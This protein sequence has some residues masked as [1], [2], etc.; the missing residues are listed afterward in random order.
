MNHSKIYKYKIEEVSK[1][2]TKTKNRDIK[3]LIFYLIYISIFFASFELPKIAFNE[4]ISLG[5]E[6]WLLLGGTL[7]VVF[8]FMS[9][10]Y[11]LELVGLSAWEVN[12]ANN[13]YLVDENNDIY[14]VSAKLNGSNY[15]SRAV[16]TDSSV[17]KVAAL[18]K[19]ISTLRPSGEF[20]M[21]KIV[22][23]YK[24]KKEKDG[25]E[26]ICD[27][28][29]AEIDNWKLKQKIYLSNYYDDYLELS[30][31]FVIKLKAEK[32]KTPKKSE[33]LSE[34]MTR[35][36]C[37]RATLQNQTQSMFIYYIVFYILFFINL[38]I[39]AHPFKKISNAIFSLFLFLFAMVIL[40]C[41]RIYAK[42]F[43]KN[44]QNP[45]YILFNNLNFI[46]A[47]AFVVVFGLF[48]NIIKG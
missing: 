6:I 4:E 40:Y 28:Y 12:Q 21:E 27:I 26:I 47:I 41:A 15:A 42:N 45:R 30:D 39:L 19:D 29:N 7:F 5:F 10:K 11:G 33:S 24:I 9:L 25:F 22:N 16:L 32:V 31:A 14:H 43:T 46:V 37:E 8:S 17:L 18:A 1:E 3:W 23:V 34:K 44:Y 2:T 38:F 20:I 36:F 35:A 48:I 13:Y